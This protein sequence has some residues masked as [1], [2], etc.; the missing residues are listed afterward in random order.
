MSKLAQ[1]HAE[2]RT[3][4]PKS[5]KGADYTSSVLKLSSNGKLGK[6]ILKGAWKGATIFTVTLEERATCPSDC[7]MWTKCYG[8]NMPFA[9]RMAMDPSE[10]MQRLEKEVSEACNTYNKVAVRLHVLG[11]FFSLDYVVFWR[12]LQH[13]FQNLYIWG[14][15]AHKVGSPIGQAITEYNTSFGGRWLVRF[16]NNTNPSLARVGEYTCAVDAPED[17]GYVSCPEQT[18]KAASC[19][20]CGLCWN[21]NVLKGIRFIDHSKGKKKV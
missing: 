7:A 14:Y 4:Y 8:D 3:V 10:L 5:R 21:H 20:D 6:R 15:T 9:H 19:G 17:T 13:K 1:A 16:S 18:G 12:K 11:D 2:A